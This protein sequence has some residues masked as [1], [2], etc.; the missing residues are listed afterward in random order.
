LSSPDREIVLLR[1]VAG[2][3]IADIVVALGVTPAAVGRAEHQALIAL[4]PAATAHGP[5]PATRQRVVL[6]PHAQTVPPNTRPGNRRTGGGHGM[7]Q[8]DSPRQ[9]RP[10]S[11]ATT[12]GIAASAQWH[13]AELAMKVARHSF[14][15]WL[16]AGEEDIPS[17]TIVHAYH[18]HVALHEAARMITMLIET[19]RVEAAVLITT[20][21]RGTDIPTQH[22]RSPDSR[23]RIP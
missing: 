22:Q 3:S 17:L 8:D 18:T 14:D 12:R 1:V 6:L 10:Y 15:R 16:T 9:H 13:D 21:A 7:N 19:F 2:V 11:D 20:P 5:L 4:Q 23:Q